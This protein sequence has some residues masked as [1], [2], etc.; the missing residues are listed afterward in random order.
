MSKL[1]DLLLEIKT[2]TSDIWSYERI[3]VENKRLLKQKKRELYNLCEHE[4]IYDECSN[5]DDR[6]KYK[7]KFCD[8]PRNINYI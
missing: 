4:W 5:W 3:I 8:L 1:D 6:C 7:C 2:L